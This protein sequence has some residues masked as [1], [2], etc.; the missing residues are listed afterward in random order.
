MWV[1]TSI[2]STLK[3]VA[4][5]ARQKSK[6]NPLSERPVGP[7]QLGRIVRMLEVNLGSSDR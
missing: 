1:M 7:H 5:T 4:G 2:L 3:G 6:G